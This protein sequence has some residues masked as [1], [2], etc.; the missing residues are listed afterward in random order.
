MWIPGIDTLN[1]HGYDVFVGEWAHAFDFVGLHNLITAMAH[2][3]CQ[4]GLC[5]LSIKNTRTRRRHRAAISL[6]RY[7]DARRLPEIDERNSCLSTD[8][9][10]DKT[11]IFCDG[12]ILRPAHLAGNFVS[13]LFL[14]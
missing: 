1:A 6:P 12:Y 5:A 13:R 11:N 4:H 9:Y 7:F 3:T 10:V 8:L 2:G 14:D